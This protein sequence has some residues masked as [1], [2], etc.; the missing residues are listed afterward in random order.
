VPALQEVVRLLDS[1]SNPPVEGA[2][3]L[4][5]AK[6]AARA[7][8]E[9]GWGSAAASAVWAELE[10]RY[11]LFVEVAAAPTPPSPGAGIPSLELRQQA[12]ERL[13]LA[14][15]A[16]GADADAAMLAAMKGLLVA[17]PYGACPGLLVSC[18]SWFNTDACRWR[19]PRIAGPCT[20][21]SAAR[22]ARLPGAGKPHAVGSP[23]RTRVPLTPTC[24]LLPA[25]ESLHGEVA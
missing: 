24:N 5:M 11:A 15:A 21:G 14:A 20:N 16:S 6:E 12:A 17:L 19:T 23:H 25:A 22:P 10:A 8:L 7:A 13:A 3:A 1:T 2:L 9:A 18:C 4:D